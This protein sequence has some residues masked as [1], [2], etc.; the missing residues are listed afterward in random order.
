MLN[1]WLTVLFCEKYDSTKVKPI[2]SEQKCIHEI[3][4]RFYL[5]NQYLALH[6]SHVISGYKPE[7]TNKTKQF[8]NKCINVVNLSAF[9]SAT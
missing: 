8:V 9:K 2:I 3:S 6:A 1:V 5:H 7:L 4:I